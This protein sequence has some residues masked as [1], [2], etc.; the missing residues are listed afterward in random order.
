MVGEERKLQLQELEELRLEAYD[1]SL[2][3][4]ERTKLIHDKNLRRKQFSVGKKVLLFN[5]RLRL[6]PS[7]LKSRWVGPFEVISVSN[8]GA[9]E[10]KSLETGK[11]FK[12]NGH[13]LKPFLENFADSKEVVLLAQP[14]Y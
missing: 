11:I 9:I 3:Y 5:S 14:N 10:I 1:S 12:V 2:W 4:K 6:L 8:F 13:L 7:K